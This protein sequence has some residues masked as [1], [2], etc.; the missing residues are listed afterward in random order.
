V[1][2][3]VGGARAAPGDLDRS[4]AEDGSVDILSTAARQVQ[5]FEMALGSNGSV[6]LLGRDPCGTC[7]GELVVSKFRSDG[8]LV[9]S[10]GDE[11]A[12]TTFPGLFGINGDPHLAI[13]SQDRAVVVAQQSNVVVTR[14]GPNG[15]VDPA[16]GGVRR[17]DTFSRSDATPLSLAVAPDDRIVVGSSW[18]EPHSPEGMVPPTGLLFGRFLTDGTLDPSFGSSGSFLFWTAG[19]SLFF[20]S[21]ALARDGSMLAAGNTCCVGR[22]PT[23]PILLRIDAGG[24]SVDPEYGTRI[25][26]KSLRHRLEIPAPYSIA[27]ES[28]FMR[29]NGR[30]DLIVTAEKTE[31]GERLSY[32]LR[33]SPSGHL[34]KKFGEDGA[35]RLPMAVDAAAVDGEGRIFAVSRQ[36]EKDAAA[37]LYGFRLHPNGRLDRT[38][39]GGRVFLRR[40]A[41]YVTQNRP[42]PVVAFAG[43][44]PMVFERGNPGCRPE[45]C[46]DKPL[47][48]RLRGGKSHVTCLG[49]EATIVGT[50]RGETLTGTGRQDVIAALGGNDTVRGKGGNDLICGG[51][52]R[53]RLVGG[54]GRDRFSVGD[55]GEVVRQ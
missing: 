12:A 44:R 6:F 51:P 1:A 35:L 16:F 30:L 15:G 47:L 4:F 45:E 39:G 36:E 28:L 8:S 29:K 9:A 18:T 27:V 7:G 37:T 53:D 5:A 42:T 25:W 26:G 13:D 48:I 3:P 34:D 50:R 49:H 11:G 20:T 17:L 22:T 23:E 31:G 38:F 33:V 10:Y 24:D 2:G 43:R 55:R 21:F 54:P 14:L 32:M 40:V 46:P 41:R 52:G 19:P